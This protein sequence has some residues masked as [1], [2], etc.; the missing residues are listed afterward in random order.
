MILIKKEWSNGSNG[1][2][3]KCTFNDGDVRYAYQ[4]SKGEYVIRNISK[5]IDFKSIN[6]GTNINIKENG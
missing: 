4:N 3:I 1:I 6:I 5:N 2:Y